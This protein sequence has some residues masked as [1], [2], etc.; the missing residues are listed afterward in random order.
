MGN[1]VGRKQRQGI[2]NGNTVISA[3]AGVLRIQEI[4]LH[5]QCQAV[6]FHINGSSRFLNGY[7]IHMSLQDDC[8]LLFISPACRLLYDNILHFVLYA[9]KIMLFGKRNQI[10]ADAFHISR[11]MGN[12]TDFFKIMPHLLRLFAF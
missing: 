8:R 12:F 7:H 4:S 6:F 10:V 1:I 11:A 9:G 3:Q 2:S 5:T